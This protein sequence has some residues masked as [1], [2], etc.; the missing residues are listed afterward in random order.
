MCKTIYNRS[1]GLTNEEHKDV[2]G[3][4]PEDKKDDDGASTLGDF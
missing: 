2:G 3:Y 4:G 1:R